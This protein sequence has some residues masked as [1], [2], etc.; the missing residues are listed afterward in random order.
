MDRAIGK[1]RH[2]GATPYTSRCTSMIN[3]ITS[4]VRRSKVELRHRK[5]CGRLAQV[6]IGPAQLPVFTL[7]RLHPLSDIARQTGTRTVADFVD[8]RDRRSAA[9]KASPTFRDLRVIPV[10]N[11]PSL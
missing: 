4:L 7:R 6:L 9:L 10:D 3:T 2:I 8:Q 1:T 11:P 5:I